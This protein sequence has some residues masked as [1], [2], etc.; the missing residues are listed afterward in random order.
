LEWVAMG[1]MRPASDSSLIAA[2]AKLPLILSLSE[3]TEG[4]II[5]YLGTSACSFSYVAL[6]KRTW[7]FTFSFIFPFDHFFFFPLLL[8]AAAK[9]LAS[10]VCCTLGAMVALQHI[11][12]NFVKL[13][14]HHISIRCARE[15]F[16]TIGEEF[17]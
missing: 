15:N 8:L 1:L 11:N 14:S 9:A 4:V 3:R 2:R 17:N 13:Y 6:S 7:L 5:L 10:L 16:Y 12:P